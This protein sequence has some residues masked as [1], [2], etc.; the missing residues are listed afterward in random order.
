MSGGD[1]PLTILPAGEHC[2]LGGQGPSEG[3]ISSTREQTSSSAHPP[4]SNSQDGMQKGNI[5]IDEFGPG[6]VIISQVA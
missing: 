4:F 6:R 3:H 2:T 1:T 5:D